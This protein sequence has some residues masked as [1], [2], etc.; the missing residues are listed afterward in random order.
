[1]SNAA[2]W[3]RQRVLQSKIA[4]ASREAWTTWLT[5]QVTYGMGG[6]PLPRTEERF[7]HA[8]AES[9]RLMLEYEASL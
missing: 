2:E 7:R 4:D 3:I 5:I 6:Q 9:E 1:M 8:C